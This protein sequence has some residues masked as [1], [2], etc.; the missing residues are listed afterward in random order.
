MSWFCCTFERPMPGAGSEHRPF[1]DEDED[2]GASNMSTKG[3]ARQVVGL[4]DSFSAA[5]AAAA[6]EAPELSPPS[7]AQDAEAEA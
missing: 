4:I 6:A 2:I 7:P 1:V 5:A 3:A